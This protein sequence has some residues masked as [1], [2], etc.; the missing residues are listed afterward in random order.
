MENV[1][2][3]GIMVFF[4]TTQHIL[5]DWLTLWTCTL[6]DIVQLRTNIHRHMRC[7]VSIYN[8][9][10]YLMCMYTSTRYHSM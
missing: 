3:L 6:H 7:D 1:T 9:Y 8:T 2:V 10:L 5:C 4:S